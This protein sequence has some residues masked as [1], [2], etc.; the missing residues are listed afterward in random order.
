[1]KRACFLIIL[2]LFLAPS[3]IA[4]AGEEDKHL[5]MEASFSKEQAHPG[6]IVS[7]NLKYRLPKGAILPEKPHPT[8]LENLSVISTRLISDG[9]IAEI[10]VDTL[11]T[12]QVPSLTFSFT[13]ADK[14]E[15]KIM[16]NPLQLKVI[17]ALKGEMEAFDVKS[18][19]GIMPVGRG[20]WEKGWPY[21]LVVLAALLAFGIWWIVRKRKR[22]EEEVLCS[23]PPDSVALKALDVLKSS[24]L[25][26]KGEI[27]AYYFSLSEI[28]RRYMEGIRPFPAYEY[29]TDEIAARIDHEE[30]RKVVKLLRQADLIKFAD[31][32]PTAM[33]KEEH[34]SQAR[35]YVDVTKVQR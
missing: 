33:Q 28:V 18:I 20:M 24:G 29:T 32:R 16:S 30:D 10:M 11:D 12:I 22:R 25:Y 15:W 31:N 17:S 23:D 34:W 8:G 3:Q 7:L 26:E 2:L 19:K 1:M 9:M 27:K 14:K 13:D 4:L 6:E 21:M 5:S 35:R